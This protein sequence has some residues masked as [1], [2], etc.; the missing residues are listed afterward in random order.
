MLG[1][2]KTHVFGLG[3][4]YGLVLGF[5]ISRLRT[6]NERKSL[7]KFINKGMIEMSKIIVESEN[8]IIVSI[9]L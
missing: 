2:G 8:S 7:E 1:L 5:Q 3:I 9:N 6:C 4:G